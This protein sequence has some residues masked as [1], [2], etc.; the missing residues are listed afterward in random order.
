MSGDS[1]I[2]DTTFEN[3][4]SDERGAVFLSFDGGIMEISDN[5][6]ENNRR[7][8]SCICISTNANTEFNPSFTSIKNNR[9]EMNEG[10]VI[11][12]RENIQV[13]NL[14]LEDNVFIQN[15]G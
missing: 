8:E 12:V 7:I 14:Y 11:S 9:F 3:N 2:R 10:I 15:S 5:K 4:D 13:S 6:F 1:Y